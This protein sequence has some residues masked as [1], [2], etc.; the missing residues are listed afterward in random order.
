MK[1]ISGLFLASIMLAG[2]AL[3][4][5]IDHSTCAEE[6][7]FFRCSASDGRPV[8]LKPDEYKMIKMASEMGAT[9]EFNVPGTGSTQSAPVG[10]VPPAMA[11][12]PAA[13]APAAQVQTASLPDTLNDIIAADARGWMFNRYD[14]NSVKNVKITEQ[15][16]DGRSAV[17]YGDYTFNGGRSGYVRVLITD[18]E[19]ECLKFWDSPSCRPLGR[20]HSQA[21]TAAALIGMASSGNSSGGGSGE[22][23]HLEYVGG[24]TAG[25][26]QR[27]CH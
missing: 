18:G 20:S 4:Q 25:H 23:C 12:K 14:R 16:A 3:A 27:I 24:N 21:L 5:Q 15:S 2:N 19:V 26:V 10:S 22:N 11:A 9:V 6:G 8:F 7:E 1:F 13:P 17:V